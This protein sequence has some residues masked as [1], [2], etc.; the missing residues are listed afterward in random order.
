MQEIT[1]TLG[2]FVFIEIFVFLIGVFI[3][4]YSWHKVL[5]Q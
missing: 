5:H 1:M 3:G 4:M 2:N